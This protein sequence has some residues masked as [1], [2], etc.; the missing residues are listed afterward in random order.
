MPQKA[1]GSQPVPPSDWSETTGL[2][3]ANKG[4]LFAVK[5]LVLDQRRLH[6]DVQGRSKHAADYTL[7]N[8]SHGYVDGK[9]PKLYI[10]IYIC[11]RGE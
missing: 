9:V 11:P 2:S 5:S 1:Q 3:E 7:M 8:T 6:S 4:P 10:Y